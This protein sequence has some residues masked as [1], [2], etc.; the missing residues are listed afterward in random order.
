MADG[1]HIAIRNRT[2]KPLAIALSGER[3]RLRGRDDGGNV[4]DYNISLIRIV[5]MNHPHHEYSLIN[6]YLKRL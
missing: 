2:R 4:A 5:T 6:I 1:L 3:R